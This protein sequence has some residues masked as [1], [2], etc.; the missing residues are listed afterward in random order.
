M[1]ASRLHRVTGRIVTSDG[2][3]PTGMD[4]QLAPAEGESGITSGAGTAAADGTFAIGGLPDGSYTLHVRQNSRPRIEDVRAGRMPA[5]M[6]G[7][8]RGESVSVPLT[9]WGEDVTDLRI[10]TSRGTTI[11]GR[12]VFEG[13]SARPSTSELRVFALPPGLAGGGWF[14]AGSSVYDFPPDGAVA[15]DGTFQLAGASGRVQLDA[16]GGDWLVK[17]ITLDGREITGEV[18]D[19]TGANAVSVIVITL[20]DELATVAGVLR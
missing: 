20:T 2:Q 14:S 12:V 16:G 19:L 4:L 5:S 7:G 17:S 1:V 8:V 9:V 13:A 3:P 15:S 10:V 11:S 18:M 6:F